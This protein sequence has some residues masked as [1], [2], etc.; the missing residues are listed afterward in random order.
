MTKFLK[1][2]STVRHAV[3]VKFGAKID[4]TERLVSVTLY[5]SLGLG[6]HEVYASLGLVVAIALI[7]SI[8]FSGGQAE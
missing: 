5:G 1:S 7:L 8:I 4:T 6:L 2:L 3:A